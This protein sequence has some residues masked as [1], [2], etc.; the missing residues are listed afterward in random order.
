MAVDRACS[1]ALNRYNDWIGYP[2]S[3]LAV[4]PDLAR[5][6]PMIVRAWNAVYCDVARKNG[7]RC[8]DLSTR[9]NGPDGTKPSGN[10]VVAD[11]THPSQAGMDAIVK[12]LVAFGYKPLSSLTTRRS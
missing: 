9:F 11:Y 1:I 3:K 7:F 8:A 10:L 6:S 4:G 5:V 12:L 2:A